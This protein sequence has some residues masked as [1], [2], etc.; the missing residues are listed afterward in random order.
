MTRRTDPTIRRL[1]KRLA[2][3]GGRGGRPADLREQVVATIRELKTEGWKQREIAEALGLH[4]TTVGRYVNGDSRRKGPPR[5][6]EPTSKRARRPASLRP[7][8]VTRASAT[9]P[10][11]IEKSDSSRTLVLGAGARVE[12]LSLDDVVELARRL[13]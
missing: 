3:E 7:V 4:Q 5:V 12:G 10:A 2:L 8:T 9:T 13:S 1:K 6:K 11:S